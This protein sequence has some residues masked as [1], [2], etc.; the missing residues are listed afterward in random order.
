MGRRPPTAADFDAGGRR[1]A[2]FFAAIGFVF[3]GLAAW[4]AL[5][6]GAL[7]GEGVVAQARVVALHKQERRL[8]PGE[9]GYTRGAVQTEV[10]PEV[11][12][13][14]REGR[15]IRLRGT[16]AP[17]EGQDWRVGDTLTLRYLPRDP[18]VVEFESGDTWFV[19]GLFAIFAVAFLLP[20]LFIVVRP[21]LRATRRRR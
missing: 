16:P 20:W 1:I 3:A 18:T 10:V 6:A 4:N 15:S 9:S 2:W 8:K 13:R 19:V 21:A 17:D 7:V 14:T 11:E 5:Q 12:F